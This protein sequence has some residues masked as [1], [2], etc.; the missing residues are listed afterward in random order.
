M[1]LVT[2]TLSALDESVTI[3]GEKVVVAAEEADRREETGE[4]MSGKEE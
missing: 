3:L 1:K 2:S 4:I